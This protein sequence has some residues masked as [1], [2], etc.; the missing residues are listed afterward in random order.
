M[1]TVEHMTDLSDLKNWRGKS[2]TL[3]LR[4]IIQVRKSLQRAEGHSDVQKVWNTYLPS[5]SPT[6]LKRRKS[7]AMAAVWNFKKEKCSEATCLGSPCESCSTTSIGGW[8][9]RQSGCTWPIASQGGPCMQILSGESRQVLG[10]GCG[11]DVGGGR[12]GQTNQQATTWAMW[13]TTDWFLL[14]RSAGC[15]KYIVQFTIGWG[16]LDFDRVL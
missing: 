16:H 2:D 6:K 10:I 8:A 13:K 7:E 5:T 4:K 3:Q 14:R 1:L 15:C 11:L 9:F 12:A